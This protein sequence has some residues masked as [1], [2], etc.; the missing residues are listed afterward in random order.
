MAKLKILPISEVLKGYDNPL[1]DLSLPIFT[2][3]NVLVAGN[4]NLILPDPDEVLRK[5]GSNLNAYNELLMDSH[6]Y[7]I[8]SARK[9]AVLSKQWQLQFIDEKREDSVLLQQIYS[10]LDVNEIISQVLNCFLYGFQPMEVIW[11]LDDDK[12]IIPVDVQAKPTEWFFYVNKDGR[13]DLRVRLKG[14]GVLGAPVDDMKLIVAHHQYTEKNP[15]GE[16]LLSRC[17]WPVTFK[18][19]GIKYWVMF[20]EKYGMPHMVAKYTEGL[21]DDKINEI[22]Q[23]LEDMVQN[24]VCAVP[25]STEID[26]HDPVGKAASAKIYQD[27]I[28]LM[29]EQMSKA[30]L[31]QTLTTE[32]TQ[33]GGNRALGQVHNEVKNEIV[34]S[35]IKIIEKFFKKLN[36]IVYFYNFGDK[37]KSNDR[38]GFNILE[39]YF[40]D[41]TLAERDQVLFNMGVKFSKSYFLNRYGFHDAEIELINEQA[42]DKPVNENNKG[43][44]FA[45]RMIETDIELIDQPK[46]DQ[47]ANI[48]SDQESVDNILSMLDV[49]NMHELNQKYLEPLFQLVNNA[50]SFDEIEKGIIDLYPSLKTDEYEKLF[51]KIFFIS[52]LFGKAVGNR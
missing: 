4:T 15:Y 1:Y 30:V 51:T 8:V 42:V 22:L 40:V 24:V 26:Y 45:Q 29:D 52:D 27:L 28:R 48:R 2:R 18:K 20:C 12:N 34:Q 14:S 49:N 31:G 10:I 47:F 17:F 33:G 6:L 25:S 3:S 19:N 9:N 43:N 21:S 41:K 39:D 5:R 11:A 38:V 36:D 37:Y 7:A 16:K 32:V 13:N 50:K 23:G 44:L 35:D 46:Y